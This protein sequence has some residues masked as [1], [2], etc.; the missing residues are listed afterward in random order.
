MSLTR[1]IAAT[2]G[3]I[4]ETLWGRDSDHQGPYPGIA[5]GGITWEDTDGVTYT[6]GI[7]GDGVRYDENT[8]SYV[9]NDVI[10][11]ASAYHN[12]RYKRENENRR[13]V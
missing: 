12:K 13:Y 8:D 7:I 2:A 5:Q 3:N 6:D 9:P 10:V 1:L 4:D 11:H